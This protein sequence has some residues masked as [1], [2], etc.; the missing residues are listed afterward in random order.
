ML[1]RIG[2]KNIYPWQDQKGW[3]ILKTVFPASL[4]KRRR[5]TKKCHHRATPYQNLENLN[6]HQ[7]REYIYQGRPLGLCTYISK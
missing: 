5:T 7:E 4:L 1:L 2:G 6:F 3:F